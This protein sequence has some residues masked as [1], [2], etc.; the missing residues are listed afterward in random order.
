MANLTQEYQVNSGELQTRELKFADSQ[1]AAS[2]GSDESDWQTSYRHGWSTDLLPMKLQAGDYLETWVRAVDQHGQ[3][4]ATEKRTVYLSSRGLD[5]SLSEAEQTRRDLAEK[6]ESVS[7]ELEKNAPGKDKQMTSEQAERMADQA[8]ETMKAASAELTRLHRAAAQANSDPAATSEMRLVGELLSQIENSKMLELEQAREK[9][10]DEATQK[11]VK[12]LHSDMKYIARSFRALVTQDVMRRH[13]KLLK[14]AAEAQ[15]ALADQLL[16]ESSRD[17]IKREHQVLVRQLRSISEDIEKEVSQVSSGS[18]GRYRAFGEQLGQIIGGMER[19]RMTGDLPALQKQ[20][21]ANASS[22]E[23]RSLDTHV[24]GNIFE[25][26]KRAM[27]WFDSK[28]KSSGQLVRD[29]QRVKSNPDEAAASLLASLQQR[30]ELRRASESAS[31]DFTRDLGQTKRALQR[32][33]E[34]DDEKRQNEQLDQVREALQ[35]L[36]LGSELQESSAILSKLTRD[37]RWQL[38]SVETRTDSPRN[39]EALQKRWEQAARQAHEANV[40]SPLIQSIE[41][42]RWDKPAQAASQRIA[43]RRWDRS[44]PKS[45]ASDLMKLSQQLAKVQAELKPAIEKARE[46]IDEAAPTISELAKEAAEKTKELSE[47]TERLS[48]EV[49]KQ[50]KEA[51]EV[52]LAQ[53]EQQKD[54]LQSPMQELREALVDRAETHDLLDSE[55]LEQARADEAGLQIVDRAAEQ[56]NESLDQVPEGNATKQEQKQ[57]LAEAAEKQADAA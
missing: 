5:L 41:K 46:V 51:N 25:N 13:S 55:E 38:N 12:S 39:W 34:E 35:V 45:A 22:L 47:D 42:L 6:L 18:Q 33:L 23:V 26:Q 50:S 19:Q 28:L 30:R 24:D 43:S 14:E 52:E 17:R 37:E 8:M 48:Q 54:R 11:A 36:E 3:S 29:F 49:E 56:T 4:V 32:I 15:R 1:L 57:A 44:E 40:E 10:D 31:R 16:D 27:D 2:E 7:A 9:Q 53:L 20:I 21:E